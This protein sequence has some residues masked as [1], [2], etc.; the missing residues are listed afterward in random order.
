MRLSIILPV[1]NVA[2]FIPDCLDSLLCQDIPKGD[3]EIIC[4]DDGSPDNSVEVIKS[5]QE[6]NDNIRLVRQENAGVS[7]ARNNGIAL[8]KGKYVWFIDPDDY[9]QANCVGAILDALDSENADLC[10][11]LYK[12]VE[13]ESAFNKDDKEEISISPQL[14]YTSMGSACQYIFR[15]DYWKERGLSFNSSLA[16][17][18]D[19]LIAFQL[20]YR[21]HVGL[22]TKAKIYRYRQR[23]GSAMHSKS[24]E[25]RKRHMQGMHDLALIYKQEYTRCEGEE[26]P[27]EVLKNVKER[28]N[29]CVQS[30]ILDLIFICKS[31]QDIKQNLAKLKIEGLYPYPIMWWK[32][33]KGSINTNLKA[34]WL[35]LLFPIKSYVVFMNWI[36]RRKNKK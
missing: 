7:T 23:A 8:A 1:Y 17:G 33:K 2:K 35:E 22:S 4:V 30:A 36:C 9:I 13:E 29:L 15:L 11:F 12:E 31:K 24:E 18:E 19:Y 21:K 32:L 25:K 34:K 5:Y 26:L 3:Y 20:N 10:D 14:G 16:Y 28:I 27:K 6:K